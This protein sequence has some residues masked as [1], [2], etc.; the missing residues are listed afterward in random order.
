[1]KERYL[2]VPINEEANPN[3]IKYD[4]ESIFD[5]AINRTYGSCIYDVVNEKII[6]GYTIFGPLY[7]VKNGETFIGIYTKSKIDNFINNG[8]NVYDSEGN[9]INIV[10]KKQKQIYSTFPYIDYTIPDKKEKT[11]PHGIMLEIPGIEKM[12]NIEKV[13]AIEK[14]AELMRKEFGRPIK[15][16]DDYLKDVRFT[17]RK[18]F[19]EKEKDFYTDFETA[20]SACPVDYSVFDVLTGECI[21]TKE[22]SIYDLKKESEEG[23]KYKE[24][25][26][27]LKDDIHYCIN[28]SSYIETSAYLIVL[29][30]MEELEKE[31]LKNE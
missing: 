15:V 31:V 27:N 25:W 8:F 12:S 29:H 13:K 11:K 2:V 17:V 16:S 23:M 6:A 24:M 18:S 5:A 3:T 26:D 21:Y 7:V 14:I 19:E 1:M 30:K 10:D 22:K 20:K 28:N 9:K 4:G